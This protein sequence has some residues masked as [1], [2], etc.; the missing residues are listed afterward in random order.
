MPRQFKGRWVPG[1]FKGSLRELAISDLGDLA[2]FDTSE[3]E[4]FLNQA[5]LKQALLKQSLLNMAL[6]NQ[7]LLK[8]VRLKQ[9]LLCSSFEL[10][11]HQNG[12]MASIYALSLWNKCLD[13]CGKGSCTNSMSELSESQTC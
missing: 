2:D 12:M 13:I 9:A 11:L 8:Q 5:I 7:A 6:V 3:N 1:Q 4:A 10:L